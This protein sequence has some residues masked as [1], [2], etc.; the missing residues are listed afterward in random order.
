[1]ASYYEISKSVR[2]TNA[3]PVDG[4]RYIAADLDKRDELITPTQGVIRAHIGVQVYVVSE[5]KLYILTSTNPSI[6]WDTLPIIT[7]GESAGKS[8]FIELLDT[9]MMWPAIDGKNYIVE[10]DFSG[11]TGFEKLKFTETKTAYNQNYGTAGQMTSDTESD[12]GT[13]SAGLLPELAKIDHL[14]NGLYYTKSEIK[15]K[16]DAVNA[17][18]KYIWDNKDEIRIESPGGDG[19]GYLDGEQ[20]L[21]KDSA[22]S[23]N[24]G[25]N[26]TC[27][28]DW[29]TEGDN[30]VYQYDGTGTCWKFLY[31]LGSQVDTTAE[32]V[33][34]NSNSS[35]K[36]VVTADLGGFKS[37]NEVLYTDDVYAVLKKLLET[38]IMPNLSP[39]AVINVSESIPTS[40]T[41]EV[42]TDLSGGGTVGFSATFNQGTIHGWT[43]GAVAT[44]VDHVGS[45]NSGV[46][47]HTG[48]FGGALT[49]VTGTASYGSNTAKGSYN[50]TAGTDPIHDS[51]GE[52][53]TGISRTKASS[54]TVAVT[55][56][57]YRLVG[58][59]STAEKDTIVDNADA[60]ALVLAVANRKLW[61]GSNANDEAVTLAAGKDWIVVLLKGHYTYAQV[62]NGD[63]A[64]LK[65]MVKSA[66][67]DVITNADSGA[68]K[69]TYVNYVNLKDAADNLSEFTIVTREMGRITN[70]EQGKLTIR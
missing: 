29:D 14:H 50:T 10:I 19:S 34:M 15:V 43:A 40:G 54:K 53:Y 4:D 20:G 26:S 52:I 55:G 58:F 2:I 11:G 42:G 61:N 22:T 21:L 18:I 56:G 51:T 13:N 69:P 60:S 41:V 27:T 31:S 46:Y 7:D 66:S 68:A 63:T 57:Y 67:G 35:K 36:I 24:T 62:V 8:N 28:N 48:G 70:P 5:N 37:G 1:M 33:N 39:S 25:G 30:G 32:K 16:L 17:G 49:A 47:T 6:V 64:Q 9:P 59:M 44:T 45:M 65:I 38:A 12:G 3:D 23:G